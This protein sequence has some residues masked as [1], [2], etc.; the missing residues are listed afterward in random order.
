MFLS[1]LD[2]IDEVTI[3]GPDFENL[4]LA[5]DVM[6]L[7]VAANFLPHPVT[8]RIVHM[9]PLVIRTQSVILSDGNSSFINDPTG[10]TVL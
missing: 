5:A 7:Q 8:L 4:S 6:I 3:T 2:M 10:I 1:S 9:T